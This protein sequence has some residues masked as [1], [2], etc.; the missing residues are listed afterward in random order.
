[1]RICCGYCALRVRYVLVPAP[2]RKPRVRKLWRGLVAGETILFGAGMIVA[3]TGAGTLQTSGHAF[4]RVENRAS[5]GR[6]AP[7]CAQGER[8]AAHRRMSC[9]LR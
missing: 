5:N 7:H 3:R 6:F 8:V 1:M 9:C 2:S 4:H